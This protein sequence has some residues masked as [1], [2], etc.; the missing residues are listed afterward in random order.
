MHAFLSAYFVNIYSKTNKISDNFLFLPAFG[1]TGQQQCTCLCLFPV[2]IEHIDVGLP[3]PRP[4]DHYG[5]LTRTVIFVIELSLTRC[6]G[7]ELIPCRLCRQTSVL[8]LS[9]RR[10]KS[11]IEINEIIRK[12]D[13]PVLVKNEIMLGYYIKVDLIF[14][15]SSYGSYKCRI[16]SRINAWILI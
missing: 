4:W 2:V 14:K 15:T 12:L 16:L 6:A 9:Y 7:L 1:D 10:T 11:S 13:S 3:N 5:D 8:S